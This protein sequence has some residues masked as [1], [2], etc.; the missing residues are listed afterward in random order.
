M[1]RQVTEELEVKDQFALNAMNMAR[2]LNK[3]AFE[4]CTRTIADALAMLYSDI[5]ELFLTVC[6]LF[7][8]KKK[9]RKSGPWSTLTPRLNCSL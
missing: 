5:L 2:A 1:I 4:K 6:N 3:A 8:K 9:H 7:L